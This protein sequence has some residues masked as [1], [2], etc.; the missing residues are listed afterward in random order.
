M[1]R[2]KISLKLALIVFAFS[3]ISFCS[4]EPP[5]PII[6]RAGKTTL[7]YS[8]FRDR[9]EMTPHIMMTS[10][11][12]KNK[13]RVLAALL[14]EKLLVEE[15]YKRDLDDREKFRTF[16]EEMQK[17][18]IV[19][20]L[21]ETEIASKIKIS[22]DEI[23]QG[24]IRSQSKL[25]L[26]VLTFDSLKQAQEAKKLIDAG[27]P[28][29]LV[30]QKFQTETFISADSVLTIDMEWGE[31]HPKLEDA[32]YSLK[33]N[34]VSQ[35]ISVNGKYFILKL[36]NRKTNI[37]ITEG[38]YVNKAPSIR[39][40]IRQRKRT[41]MFNQYIRSLMKQKTVRVSHEIFDL[42]ATELEKIYGIDDSLSRR[43][44]PK[45]DLSPRALQSSDLAD[46]L[47]DPFARFNDG[48]IWTVE[49]FIKKL[50]VGPYR[51][52][53][54]SR[55][56]FRNS[57]RL[58]VRRMVE[59]ETMAKKGK[60]L[61]L[62]KTYYV[63]YQTKMWGDSYLGQL[64]RNTIV[65]TVSISDE[66]VQKY[67]SLHPK[68]YQRPEMINLHEILVDDAK[69]AQQIYQRIK[70]GEDIGKLARKYNK[71]Q[72]SQKTNGITGYFLPSAFGNVG[73]AAKKLNIGDIGGPVKTKNN[74]YSVF[75]VLDKKEASPPPLRQIWNRVRQDAL[76]EKQW[77]VLDD[78]LVK[79]TDNYDVEVNHAVLDTLTT[80]DL[81]MLVLKKHYANRTAAP[82]VTPL[83][84][85]PRWLGKMTEIYPP[86]K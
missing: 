3:L 41:A 72:I 2:H 50:S 10:N 83:H 18:A 67:Y 53:Y 49:K 74:Q 21:F 59:F 58:A 24:F 75:K 57:L 1:M 66:E 17:E 78:F 80:Y 33:P 35:P 65:D 7:P 19:E 14:G 9:Y 40:K 29:D 20:K 55:K 46:H 6:A 54:K 22:D 15:A 70:N 26:K 23:K 11:K 48:T 47:N 85:S 38:D 84:K 64:M 36:V 71:R 31:A 37:F 28:L 77:Q 16:V 81:N 60:K 13:R 56:A 32:A 76:V 61:G 45:K 8:E 44:T 62:D 52:N 5:E 39:K 73:E 43:K 82:F 12:E 68:K 51:L 69:L 79:L 86:Q 27:T 30:K 34:E 25:S 63:Q 4:K 42:V